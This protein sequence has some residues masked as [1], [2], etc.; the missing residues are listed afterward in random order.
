LM[1]QAAKLRVLIPE[2]HRL[3]IE[4]PA[5]LPPGPAEVIVLV[6]RDEKGPSD[7]HRATGM[8]RGQVWIADDFDGPLPDDIQ[9]AFEGEP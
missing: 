4:L 6:S 9:R 5:D 1:V 2:N 7:R 3:Q 8:D